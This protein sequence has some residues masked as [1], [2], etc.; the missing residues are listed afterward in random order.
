VLD[1]LLLG[2][3]VALTWQ[4]MF[5]C[6][7][8]VFV[9]TLIGVL[10]GIG[11]P[12]TIALLLPATYYVEPTS[13]IIMLAG[14]YYGAMYGGSIT[15][16]L[17]NIPGE[18][19]SVVTCLDGYQ[20]ARQGRAGVALGISTI[21]SFIAGTLGIVGLMVAAPPLAKFA[22]RFGPPEYFSL[23]FMAFSLVIY[24]ASQSMLKAVM[25]AVVGVLV[26][27]VGIDFVTGTDR[28]SYGSMTLSDGVGLIPVVIGLFGIAE[29]LENT[30]KEAGKISTLKTKFKGLFPTLKDW[31]DSLGPIFRGTILGFFIGILPGGGTIMA[32]FASYALEKKVSK[33]PEQFGKGAIQGVAAPESANNAASSSAF[34]PLMTLGLPSNAVTA[35]LLGALMIHGIRPGPM[36]IQEHPQLF[37]GVVASM[38][39]G[40][41][42]LVILNLPVIGLWVRLLSM[43]Y[44]ILFP[45]ILL[46]CLVGVYGVNSNPWEVMIMIVFGI[47][48]YLMRKFKYEPAPFVFA[49]VLG[50]LME[51]ALRQSLFLSKGS[52]AIFFTR[53]ISCI[54]IVIGILLFSVP[55]LPWFKRKRLREG[56]I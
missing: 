12:T 28:F 2:F 31:K 48:G 33:H 19:A 49:F 55:A 32:S 56:E 1:Q 45:L 16:I 24:L 5:Y 26:G 6:F 27:T 44:R 10:P 38:Y 36:L 25:I 18:A 47:V 3:S 40:N 39:V 52:F 46:F 34:I 50:R 11:P 9:G 30:E 37:W 23:I 20:M 13:A 41:V 22:L 4:N 53:P 7:L 43:P 14:I 54:L 35:L 51:E 42:M 8:G 29:V 17:V 15:S 21:G